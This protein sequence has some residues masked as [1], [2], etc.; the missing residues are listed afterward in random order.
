MG[1]EM[2]LGGVL[3]LISVALCGGYGMVY[4]ATGETIPL[5]TSV[6]WGLVSLILILRVLDAL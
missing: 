1:V 4:K 6:V 2:A 5:V 3:V